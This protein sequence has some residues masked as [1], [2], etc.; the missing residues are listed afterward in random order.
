MAAASLVLS[1]GAAF[2]VLSSVGDIRTEKNPEAGFF[3]DDTRYLSRSTMEIEGCRLRELSSEVSREYVSQIDLSMSRE[4]AHDELDDPKLWFHLRRRQLIERD[5]VER[6]ELSNY[7]P[8]PVDVTLVFRHEADFKDLFEVRGWR[9]TKRGTMHEPRVVDVAT[10]EFHYTGRDGFDYR[11]RVRYERAPDQLSPGTASFRVHL[12]PLGSWS[13]EFSVTVGRDEVDRPLAPAPFARRARRLVEAH[14]EWH[15]GATRVHTDDDYFTQS[16]DRGLSDLYSLRIRIN[17]MLTVT[18]GIPWFAAPF[19]RDSLISAFQS[20]LFHA[21]PARETLLFLARYQGETRDEERDEEPGKILHELRRGEMARTGEI[22][23]RPYYGSIDA[24]PLFLILID[25]YVNFTNDIEL[26][27]TL[28]RS[29]EA[30]CRFVLDRCDADPRGLLTYNVGHGGRLRNQGWKDSADCICFPDGRLAEGPIALVEVQG[31][32]VDGLERAARLLTRVGKTSLVERSLDRAAALRS[33]IDER[34]FDDAGVCALAIDG[35]GTPVMTKTSNPGHLLFTSAVSAERARQITTSLLEGGLWSGW[36][37][38]TLSAEHPA[39]N[40]LSYHRGS[41]W[42]HDNSLAAFG[43][44]RYG[45]TREAFQVL[46][47]MYEASLH[48]RHF[49]LPELFCGIGFADA[50]FPVLYPVA[51]S[52]QAWSSAAPF[53]LLRAALGIFADAP[54]GE[55]RIYNPT[56]PAW[57][58]EVVLDR[59]HVGK[60]R[61]KIRF[62]RTGA[63]CAVDVLEQEGDPIRVLVELSPNG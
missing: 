9:R 12:E 41:I 63:A 10:Y 8:G 14:H 5:Y 3:H 7:D 50:D 24:T 22:P 11:T 51:C 59:F 58:G 38:R 47:A 60:T 23:H 13:L 27:E 42:P 54:R 34:Y 25:E 2:A 32:A 31:Y 43:M 61:L 46:R 15:A 16:L 55:L 62:T 28:A 18:A 1:N 19:G 37:I 39:Y 26:V 44:A 21:S 45:W 30:A 33:A 4:G 53:L 52:P 29:I 57:L 20:L 35:R 6:I 56:L 40:P 17:G 36:G 49:Q 48:F